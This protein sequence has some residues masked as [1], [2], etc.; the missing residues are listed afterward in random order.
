MRARVLVASVLLAALAGFGC[1]HR[2]VDPQGQVHV[3]GLV[4][5][6]LPASPPNSASSLRARGVG[7]LL[8]RD[9]IGTALSIGYSD[10]TLTVIPPEGCFNIGAAPFSLDT[11]R[12]Q[13]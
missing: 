10:S 8:S 4:D 3:V 12:R 6:T 9:A 1:A 11:S 5:V 13:P 7:L 2:Y